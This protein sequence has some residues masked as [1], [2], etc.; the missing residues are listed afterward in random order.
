M[1]IKSDVEFVK[2]E[3]ESNDTVEWCDIMERRCGENVSEVKKLNGTKVRC[4]FSDGDW[5]YYT[6]D[7]LEEYIILEKGKKYTIADNGAPVTFVEEYENYAIFE[8]GIVFK[9][10]GNTFTEYDPKPEFLK[11]EWRVEMNSASVIVKCGD[12]SVA[13]FTRN[14]C[15]MIGGLPKSLGFNLDED[16]AVRVLS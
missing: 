14:G 12:F 6:P 5:Y 3:C 13:M 9:K 15:D 16:D 7:C 8:G 4:I 1:R 10:E 11:K 2:R